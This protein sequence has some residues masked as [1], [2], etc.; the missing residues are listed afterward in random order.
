MRFPT[1]LAA[2]LLW[3]AVLLA[4]FAS[5]LVA[6]A[7]ETPADEAQAARRLQAAFVWTQADPTR[8]QQYAVF[9]K[10]LD[11]DTA[12]SKA[13]LRLFADVRYALWI[14][15]AYVERGPCRFDPKRPEYD[16]LDVTKR[17]RKGRNAVA[18]L[19]YYAACVPI[20]ESYGPPDKW[21]KQ[22]WYMMA[23]RPGL[24]AEVELTL[25]GGKRT[26][27]AT[28]ASWR[29]TEETRY[30]PSSPSSR[31]V[32]E[33][34]DARRDTGD[35]T[36]VNF[37][38]SSW[39]GALPLAGSEWGPL[40]P[41]SIPLLREQEVQNLTLVAANT[42]VIKPGPL[43]EL[44][45][46]EL[47]TGAEVVIDCGREV[48]AYTVLDFD[49]SAGSRLEISYATRFFDTGRVPSFGRSG[50]R[51]GIAGEY[52]VAHHY[53]ARE[54]RQTFMSMDTYGFKYV[55]LR[56]ADGQVKLHRV[57]LVDRLYPFQ[58]LGRFASNDAIVDRVWQAGVRTVEVCCEDAHVDC[59]DSERNEWMAD[60]Y[61]MGYPV[62]RVALAG[63]GD[64]GKPRYADGRLLKNMLRHVALSQSPDGRLQ[65]MRPSEYP[66]FGRHGVIDDYSCLWVQA[67]AEL[68]C[69]DGDL[70][71]VREVWP[72]MV[73]S[74][75]YY[76]KRRTDRGLVQAM[77]FVYFANPL[78]YVDCE[79]ATVNAYLYRSLL[80]TA[81]LAKA[82][83]DPTNAARFASAAAQ[84]RAAY[85]RELWDE[86]AGA[87][88]GAIVRKNA[89]IPADDPPTWTRP[90]KL[91]VDSAG[92]TQ[93]TGHAAVMALYYDLVPTERKPR[94]FAFMQKQFPAEKPDPYTYAFYLETLYRHDTKEGD[95]AALN[96][97]RDRWGHMT[98][99][100][101]GT[102][103]EHWTGG[104]FVHESGA[105]PAYF[106]SS[107]VLGVRTQGPCGARQLTIDPRLGDLNR[108]EG[109]TLSEFGPV[110][111]RWQRDENQ[112]LTFGINNAT[113]A[114]AFLSLRL[115][116]AKSTLIVDGK[117]LL[118]QGSFAAKDVSIQDGRVRF[119]LR[120][121]K[122]SGRLA[123]EW[124][125]KSREP[126]NRTRTEYSS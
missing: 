107:Y 76:L 6:T 95:R 16:V 68:Y 58:R 2:L 24:A 33:N 54:G 27:Q 19:V 30:L 49:A 59:S 92:R 31:G 79:G 10:T 50:G 120:P 108:A 20:D 65:P 123:G 38:E 98:K 77:E 28:D 102:T 99:Y 117:T 21:P 90:C 12:P 44:L 35:W 101:T 71:L 36:A 63:P 3:L 18:V 29:W 93:P 94:V 69:R 124:E 105:H 89:S 23:H 78:A 73:K 45:P 34:I 39:T 74:L 47:P 118:R 15:G 115:P 91:R 9:R 17:L 104:S 88:R 126:V 111:V 56:V 61:K 112:M 113:K 66:V 97:I 122:H 72:V 116:D 119:P 100:E 64:D 55:V 86:P 81:E 70:A 75:D 48:Q 80:D 83:N 62:S 96:T 41:R 82:V 46:A 25:P 109:T 121:G 13:L 103:S 84:L 67:V 42:N 52:G 125:M 43:E 11:M 87:Y 32:H 114:P 40:C 85:N 37:D 60:G 8:E 26:L 110:S 22:C 7:A 14:N 5:M 57:R 51:R 53:T 1:K 4:T 106:L